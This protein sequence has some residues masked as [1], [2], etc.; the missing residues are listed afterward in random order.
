MSLSVGRDSY[1]LYIQTPISTCTTSRLKK[2][3]DHSE[4]WLYSGSEGGAVELQVSN[5]SSYLN[6]LHRRL[7]TFLTK[8]PEGDQTSLAHGS[9]ISMFVDVNRT[10]IAV[11]DSSE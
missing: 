8:R 1:L 9:N 11:K 7:R 3:R 4:S 10:I 2:G 6:R 5:L